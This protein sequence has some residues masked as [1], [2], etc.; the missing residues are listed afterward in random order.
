[1]PTGGLAASCAIM[2]KREGSPQPDTGMRN[3]E[4][5]DGFGGKTIGREDSDLDINRILDSM[6][7]LERVHVRMDE[8]T[9]I[10]PGK[11]TI[12]GTVVNIFKNV[13]GAA[14]L[15]LPWTFYQG[16]T[17]FS[18][19]S[20]VVVGA[21]NAYSFWALGVMAGGRF[22]SFGQLWSGTVGPRWAWVVDA[23]LFV[24]GALACAAYMIIIGE[25]IPLGLPW[26]Y[27]NWFPQEFAHSGSLHFSSLQFYSIFP[28]AAF[29]V[30]P[31]CLLRQ[32]GLLAY[33]SAFGIAATMFT[34]MFVVN[35]FRSDGP[36]KPP[37]GPPDVPDQSFQF[38]PMLSVLAIYG[39]N[40]S[41][42]YN[43]P[44]YYNELKDS[45]PQKFAFVTIVS[46]SI[47]TAVCAIFGWLGFLRFGS[48]TENNILNSFT[49]PEIGASSFSVAVSWLGI[50][51]SVITNYPLV[52]N[53]P[54]QAFFRLTS[55]HPFEQQGFR[56]TMF[57]AFWFVT[58]S[59]VIGWSGIQLA[60]LNAIK[61]ATT[62]VALSV[63]M[64]GFMLIAYLKNRTGERSNRNFIPLEAWGYGELYQS[65]F[66]SNAGAKFM[67]YSGTFL[68][69]IGLINI[70]FN[71]LGLTSLRPTLHVDAIVAS[72][73]PSPQG[74]EMF[75]EG[76]KFL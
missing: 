58:L 40:F 13:V 32:L 38:G 25:Q 20:L 28:V 68:C 3:S 63:I 71:W 48:F 47:I 52:Y 46:Y 45:S 50:A 1:M 67:M 56:S 49:L 66:F 17:R 11:A 6:D 9:E 35:Q 62:T 15:N 5:L 55:A 60:P 42:H 39:A 57:L 33:A 72:T 21:I 16:T 51:F 23:M 22:S 2:R 18:M 65:P 12:P 37:H 75:D 7:D 31:L 44:S 19:C 54:K 4:N 53:A 34:F 26:I 29:I 14:F 59:A 69:G 8:V 64:P 73:T 24:N 41:C 76:M 36:Y 30:F 27:Q 74:F 70:L 10:P 43:A 61:G